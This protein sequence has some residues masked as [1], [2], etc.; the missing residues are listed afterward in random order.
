MKFGIILSVLEALVHIPKRIQLKIRKEK[1]EMKKTLEHFLSD[2]EAMVHIR[3][4]FEF[5]I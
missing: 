3:Q 5:F 1:A 4:Y 2:P